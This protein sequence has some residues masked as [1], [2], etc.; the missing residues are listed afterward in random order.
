MEQLKTFVLDGVRYEIDSL[1]AKA[2]NILQLIT[3]FRQTT[4]T[5]IQMAELAIDRL[6]SE[7]KTMNGE[8]VVVPE[9]AEAP[10]DSETIEK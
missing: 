2:K 3:E 8:F 4:E 7:L 1:P 10:V 6:T 9:D 5:K